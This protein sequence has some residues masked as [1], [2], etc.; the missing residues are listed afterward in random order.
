V[1]T[2]HP[3]TC[4]RNF[5]ELLRA[6][7]A[8]QLAFFHQV[9]TPA[10]WTEGQDVLVAAHVSDRAARAIFPKGVVHARAWYRTTP[11]PP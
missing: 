5:Y 11:Q 10:N 2:R 9:A 6:I 8:V 7:D 1:C 3:A 4:G